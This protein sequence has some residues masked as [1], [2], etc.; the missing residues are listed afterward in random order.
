MKTFFK[1]FFASFLALVIFTIIGIF[2]LNRIID[3]AVE[4][5]KRIVE[6]KTVLVIDLSKPLLEQKT[7]SGL[8]F[9]E[10][11]TASVNGLFDVVRAIKFAGTDS[12]VKGIYIK[13][14]ANPNGFATSEELRNALIAFKQSKKFLIAYS[15]TISQQA[16]YIA[17]TAD[18]LYCHP[19][20]MLDWKGFSMQYTFFKGML[21]KLEIKP[22]I[23]YAGQFKSAT[24]PYR[25]KQMTPASRLQSMVFLNEMYSMFLLAA[26]NK[27]GVDTATLHLLADGLL[28]RK[29]SDAMQYKLI[30]GLKYDDE[31]KEEI[32]AK[33]GLAKTDKIP[34][35]T[36]AD[37]IKAVDWKGAKRENKIALIYAEG[38]IVDGQGED[39]EI[40]GN[41]YMDLI[42][43]AR[44]DNDIKAV[45]LRINS[46]GGSAMASEIIWRE[47]TLTRKEK[48]VIVS[49]GDYAASGAYYIA[50]NADSI[51]AQPN[52]LTGS[53]GVFSIYGDITGLMNNK[54][55]ITFDGVKTSPYADFGSAFRPMTDKEKQVAQAGVDSI[56]MIFKTRVSEGRHIPLPYVDSIARGRIW[57]GR[58]AIKL[59]LIDRIGNLQDAIDCAARMAKL[60][61]YQL[62]EL[63]V[64]QN[65]WDKIFNLKDSKPSVKT[66]LLHAGLGEENA[67]LL[68]QISTVKSWFGNTQMRLPFFVKVH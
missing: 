23:F 26:A 35:M 31:V 56:Y 40:G 30:D 48:P 67:L 33:I 44:L 46:G 60:K 65:F 37:Y 24:E 5:E 10:G 6:A 1:I 41:R 13:C 51:F 42:R 61:N 54:L 25:E 17:N 29:A 18:K 28:I 12:A 11:Q 62:K 63:P 64:T 34:F 20:G 50:C 2:I 32:Q 47:V 21:D 36:V 38:E 39:E 14:A 52:T 3:D 55:G 58:Q 16:Y 4:P 53:I 9:P 49:V 43:K 45:V 68:K 15:N 7:E 19:Q 59:K 8:S 22:E 66:N 27:T 57:S